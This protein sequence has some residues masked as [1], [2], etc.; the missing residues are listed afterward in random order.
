MIELTVLIVIALSIIAI[1]YFTVDKL[2][3]YPPQ[4]DWSSVLIIIISVVYGFVGTLLV[5]W[6]D[7]LRTGYYGKFFNITFIAYFIISG[8]LA[9]LTCLAYF[10][11]HYFKSMR[12][13]KS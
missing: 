5:H 3:G 8:F 6:T 9:G 2:V 7:F 13:D 4:N 12:E 1:S 10:A 11:V